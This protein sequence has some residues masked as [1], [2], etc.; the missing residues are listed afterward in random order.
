[1]N[2]TQRIEYFLDWRAIGLIVSA[3]NISNHR[4]AI[5]DQSCRMCDAE[6]VMPKCMIEAIRFRHRAILIQQE[7]KRNRMLAEKLRRP[8]NA[9]PFF[10]GNICEVGTKSADL[11]FVRL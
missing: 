6:S 11:F 4:T 8:P 9:V 5:D 1:M 10:S 7:R 2:F 3:V